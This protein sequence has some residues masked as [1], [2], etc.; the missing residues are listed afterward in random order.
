MTKLSAIVSWVLIASTILLLIIGSALLLLSPIRLR[1]LEAMHF[2]GGGACNTIPLYDRQ[3]R[4][5][6]IPGNAEAEVHSDLPLYYGEAPLYSMGIKAL[7]PNKPPDSCIYLDNFTPAEVLQGEALYPL[8][9]NSTLSSQLGVGESTRLKVTAVLQ[10]NFTGL[11][12]V[13]QY[14][15]RLDPGQNLDLVFKLDA[16]QFKYSQDPRIVEVLFDQ[17]IELEWVIA[18]QDIA[19]GEQ[20]IGVTVEKLSGD[21]TEQARLIGNYHIAIE[22]QPTSPIDP[23]LLSL[24]S[25]LG[26]VFMGGLAVIKTIYDMLSKTSTSKQTKGKAKPKKRK[27]D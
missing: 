18:P 4:L 5:H 14:L 25:I 21:S 26:S 8:V 16:P 20:W 1:I 27:T 11:G 13:H 9:L 15:V 17:P 19:A 23:K 10:S 24:L 3:G 7:D 2:R 6:E 12:Y 22:V